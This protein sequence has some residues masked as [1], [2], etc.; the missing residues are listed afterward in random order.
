M[1]EIRQLHGDLRRKFGEN[2][3][4]GLQCHKVAIIWGGHGGFAGLLKP[5]FKEQRTMRKIILAAAAGA[6]ALTLSA[7]SEKTEDAAAETADAAMAD[8]EANADAAGEAVDGAADAT[9]EAAGDAAAATTE[10]AAAAEG[11]MQDETAAEA[12][13]D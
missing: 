10:A 4:I 6:A 9:A 11:E 5:L 7:C 3:R 1:A 12:K 13:A 2:V 8:A